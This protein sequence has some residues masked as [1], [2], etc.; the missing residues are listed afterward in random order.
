MGNS[1]LCWPAEDELPCVGQQQQVVH[2]VE[3]ITAW[4]VQGEDHCKACLFD[5][6]FAIFMLLGCFWNEG[7]RPKPA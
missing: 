7:K 1:L 3:H 4:A 6:L 5:M 2:L